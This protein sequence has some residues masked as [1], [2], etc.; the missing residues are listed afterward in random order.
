MRKPHFIVIVLCLFVVSAAAQK[1]PNPTQL[2]VVATPEQEKLIFQG[3][4]LHD[5]KKYDEALVIY[6]KLLA[7]MPDLTAALYEKSLTL[8]AK[9]D[10]TKAMETAY[11]GAKYKSEQLPL[12]YSIMAN[13]LDDA[14]KPDEALNIYRQA[15][16]IL[17]AEVGTQRHLASVYYNIGLTYVRQ[18]K[19]TEAR[20]ELKK[21]IE[22]NGSYAS[23]HYLLSVVYSGTKYQV[24]AF[25]A[26]I[27]FISLELNTARSQDAA[28]VIRDVLK[29]APKDPKTGNINIFVNMGGPKDEGDYTMYELFLGTLT[30]PKDDKE[31]KMTEDEMFVSGLDGL[32]DIITEDKNL[33]NTFVGKQYVPFVAE[34]KQKGYAEILG[35]T[36]LYL[37][38]KADAMKWLEAHDAKFGEFVAWTKAYQPPK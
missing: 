17:K 14:G 1:L 3:N 10:K 33:K 35:Y 36:V 21:A 5:A 27:R 29:P 16:T 20:A 28:G 19:Y 24:P 38:G 30:T 4:E 25:L 34:L 31:K 12:F 26:A 32:I 18:K 15:E 23:P 9:G 11:L 6:D 37:S 2:P 7:E 13:C 22:N 8:Y